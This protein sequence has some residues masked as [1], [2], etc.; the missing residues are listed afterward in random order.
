MPDRKYSPLIFLILLLGMSVESIP[1]QDLSDVV[2]KVSD[3][4]LKL[5]AKLKLSEMLRFDGENKPV[6]RPFELVVDAVGEK[7]K[8]AV[9]FGWAKLDSAKAPDG[10][11]CGHSRAIK[12]L[13]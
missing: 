9:E 5:N 10:N 12:W 11:R 4:G 13:F 2:P 1:A 6:S 8:D 3:A 7:A